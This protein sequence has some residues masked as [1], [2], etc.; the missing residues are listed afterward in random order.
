MKSTKITS[1]LTRTWPYNLNNTKV[2]AMS[3]DISEKEDVSSDT[4]ITGESLV[5]N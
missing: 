3:I 4:K 5:E 2:M 1:N